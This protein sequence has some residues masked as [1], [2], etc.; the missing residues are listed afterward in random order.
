[1]T[2]WPGIILALYVIGVG[3]FFAARWRWVSRLH[4]EYL[5]AVAQIFGERLQDVRASFRY[6]QSLLTAKC[7]QRSVAL[8]LKRVK[9]LWIP[10]VEV[11]CTASVFFCLGGID[12]RENYTSQLR[13][14]EASEAVW[15]LVQRYRIREVA[16]DPVPGAADRR[17]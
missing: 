7:S 1:M 4:R 10:G 12:G 11:A 16:I 3:V 8:T 14:A 13:D 6:E 15:R 17:L 9:H 5:Q 2:W